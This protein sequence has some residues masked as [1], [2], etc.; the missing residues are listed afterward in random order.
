VSEGAGFVQR[1]VEHPVF[2]SFLLFA[3]F[4]AFYGAGILVVTW[5]LA[6]E[7]DAPIWVSIV[8]LLC[9]MVFSRLLFKGIKNLSGKGAQSAD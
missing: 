5:F 9:S 8:F 7:A 6:S 1:V 2:Q 3:I 4:R